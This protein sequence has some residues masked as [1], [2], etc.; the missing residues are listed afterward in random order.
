MI[1]K[2]EIRDKFNKEFPLTPSRAE[3]R[4]VWK[5]L[6]KRSNTNV[7]AG[8]GSHLIRAQEFRTRWPYMVQ[9]NQVLTDNRKREYFRLVSEGHGRLQ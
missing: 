6:R 2:K 5:S 1:I 8:Q 7:P 4:K 3:R 9:I